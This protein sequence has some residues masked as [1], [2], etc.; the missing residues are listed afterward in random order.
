MVV[1][2]NRVGVTVVFMTVLVVYAPSLLNGFCW[3]DRPLIVENPRITSLQSALHFVAEDMWDTDYKAGRTDY[4]RP[5]ILFSYAVDHAL[6]GAAPF[7]Y[8]LTN[9]VL[10]AATAALLTVLLI[11]LGVQLPFAVLGALL[12]GVHPLT[13][14]SVA[15]VS[16]RTD[17]V[18][19]FFILIALL[20]DSKRSKWPWRALSLAALALGLLAKE[21]AVVMPVAAVIIAVAMGDDLNGALRRRL[22]LFGLLAAYFVLRIALFGSAVAAQP[23]VSDLAARIIGAMHLFGLLV[24]PTA[25][26]IEYGIDMQAA[27]LS[28]SAIVGVGIVALLIGP[29]VVSARRRGSAALREPAVLL[30]A[31]GCLIS[32]SASPTT[33]PPGFTKAWTPLSA[34]W[35]C[36]RWRRCTTR[37]GFSIRKS[38]VCGLRS[39]STEPTWRSIRR[40]R[41]RRTISERCLPPKVVKV[42]PPT[43]CAALPTSA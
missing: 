8:H 40:T 34:R 28:P 24:L 22:D 18:C 6:H 14:E 31:L 4:Y 7:G 25:S 5:L 17:V 21:L 10:H 32:T 13:S 33:T 26:R 41:R 36:R 2:K 43:Y 29:S 15:W 3:D 19:T 42:K 39:K 37:S 11:L 30:V 20:A 38:A 9:I 35:P 27:V 1:G 12:F 16:G 23:R